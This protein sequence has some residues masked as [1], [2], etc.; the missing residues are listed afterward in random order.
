[1]PVPTVLVCGHVTL[2]RIGDGFV[3]GGSAYYSG[4]AWRALGARVR[5]LTAADGGYPRA[6][7][8]GLDAEIVPAA[9]TTVFVNI[10][11]PDGTR[12]QRVEARAP[13]LDPARLPPAWRGPDVLHLAPVLGEVDVAAFRAAAGARLVGLAVQGLVRTVQP[14]GAVAQPR[15]EFDPRALAGVD[16][17]CLGEDDVRGQ[18]D[19]LD[20]LVRA[21]PVV[22]FTQGARGSEIV[23]RGRTHRVGVFPV[24]EVDP[25]GAGDVFASAF[26][27]GLARG[28]DPVDA[29]RLGA[30]AG[31]VVVEARGGEAL[32]RV[33]E[34]FARAAKVPVLG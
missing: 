19:L 14:D 12:T 26:L 15:W 6:A 4:Q 30:A 25:V 23:V 21:V 27:L 29:A 20:R 34:A 17:V 10:H 24:E 22:A 11:R 31:S 18:G 13:A 8:S 7:L 9:A 16:A 5:V 33:G 1:M 28:E 2:D 3:P 32:P